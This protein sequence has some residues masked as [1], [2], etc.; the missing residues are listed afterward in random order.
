PSGAIGHGS[1]QGIAK[2]H[3]VRISTG[4]HVSR[5]A[6][7]L[8]LPRQPTTRTKRLKTPYGERTSGGKKAGNH[9]GFRMRRIMFLA[10]A[11][12]GLVLAAPAATATTTVQI[13]RTGFVPATVTINQDDA[14][15]WTNADTINHQVVANAGS[16]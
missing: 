15:T 14:V 2:T 11:S 7:D 5:I 10:V 16:F 13:K 12:L 6:A 9:R 1:G 3:L 8:D 4:F